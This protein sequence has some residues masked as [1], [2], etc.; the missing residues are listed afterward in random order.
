MVR[1]MNVLLWAIM[2][3]GV[4]IGVIGL[5]QYAEFARVAQG[6]VV[7]AQSHSDDAQL[8]LEQVKSRGEAWGRSAE[9]HAYRQRLSSRM[10]GL[11][12]AA[13]SG[14][15]RVPPGFFVFDV[16]LVLF[17]ATGLLLV[18][19]YTLSV[20]PNVS[21]SQIVNEKMMAGSGSELEDDQA[22]RRRPRVL[23]HS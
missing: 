23:N 18:R 19:R 17:S 4:F 21:M 5:R 7:F 3:I 15:Q 22:A 11:T 20:G 13:V 16:C 12:A 14:A 9:G 10:Q 1:V 2:L 6:H 8:F